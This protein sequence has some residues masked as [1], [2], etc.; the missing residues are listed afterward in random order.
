MDRFLMQYLN[1]QF[2]LTLL[3]CVKKVV[4]DFQQPVAPTYVFWI[5][6]QIGP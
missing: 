4:L 6:K 5:G 3:E 2:T 1:N